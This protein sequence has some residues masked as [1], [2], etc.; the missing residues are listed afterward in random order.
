MKVTLLGTGDAT[1]T[2]LIGCECPTCM[3]AHRG[4]KSRRLRFSVLVESDKGKVLIDTGP[5]LRQQM[6]ENNIVHV[7]GVI[8]THGHYDHYT[9]FAEFHRVQSNVDVYGITETLDYILDYLYFLKPIRHDVLMYEPF[10]LIGLTF[11]LFEV[12]HPPVKKAVGV[13]ICERNKK[14]VIT[15]D[16]QK[17]IPPRSL[18]LIQQPD[19]LVVDA[20]VPPTI[21]V[22]KHMNSVEAMALAKEIEAKEI[23]M[24]HL[25]HYF[26]P[27]DEESKILPLGY[28]GMVFHI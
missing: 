7:D 2:P 12:K 18:E 1:G 21:K 22:K 23:V 15:S 14:V 10:E 4:G 27:H 25:S 8:W 3:D 16:A 11:T 17:D 28:D 20:I 26:K 9:G 24:T 19:L 5:D 13:M 6:L